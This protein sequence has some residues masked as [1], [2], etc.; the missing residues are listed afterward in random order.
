[1]SPRLIRALPVRVIHLRI[2]IILAP[3][4]SLQD[5][6]PGGGATAARGATEF[7]MI[8]ILSS[9]CEPGLEA[10]ARAVEDKPKTCQLYVRGGDSHVDK[11]I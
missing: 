4:G 3:I 2:P 9:A 1:M 7:G 5:F 6:E 10:V 11:L 8:S